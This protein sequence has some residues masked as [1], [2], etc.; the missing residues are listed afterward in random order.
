MLGRNAGQVEVSYAAFLPPIS[1]NNVASS[2]MAEEICR[3]ERSVPHSRRVTLDQARDCR[4]VE[5]IV[6][7]VGK[8]DHVDRGQSI[9]LYPGRNPTSGAGKLH[10]RGALAPNGIDQDVETGHLDEEGRMSHPGQ[11]E[12][13]RLGAGNHEMRY[14]PNED[15]RIRVGPARIPPPFDQRPFEEIQKTMKLGRGPWISEPAL[16][17]MMCG[18]LRCSLC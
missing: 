3:P 5:M 14:C 11:G 6:M 12:H 18:E 16:W 1:F 9:E 10:R 7:V 13:S 2:A 15:A 4:S 17:P 8:Y